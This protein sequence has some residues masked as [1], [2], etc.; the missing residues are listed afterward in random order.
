MLSNF[1]NKKNNSI[2]LILFITSYILSIAFFSIAQENLK[3][4]EIFKDIS[5]TDIK[6]TETYLTSL[7]IYKPAF[8]TKE[9]P[10][11]VFVHGGNWFQGDK[12]GLD[13]KAKYFTKSGWILVNVNYRLSPEVMHPVHTQDVAKAIAWVYYNITNYKGDS[14]KIF[15]IGYSSGAHIAAL[16][17]TDEKYLKGEGLGLEI[18]KGIIL[19]ESAYYDIPKRIASEPYDLTMHQMAFGDNPDLWYDASPINHIEKDKNIP[20]FLLVHTELNERHHFQAVG[21]A[22]ALQRSG[23][24]ARTYYAKDKDHVSLNNDL[25]KQDDNTTK[26]IWKFLNEIYNENRKNQK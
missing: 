16:V 14:D 25:G 11:I 23:I 12:G 9:C 8:A 22:Q 4:V 3:D 18:L 19:L 7:D 10:V 15:I 24:F 17:A 5:Y 6:G 20:S 21:L 26:A 1:L 13:H 2:F